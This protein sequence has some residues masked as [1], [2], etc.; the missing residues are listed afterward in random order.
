MTLLERQ[1]ECFLDNMQQLSPIGPGGGGGGGV[2][3]N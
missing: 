3:L 2:Q 1:D